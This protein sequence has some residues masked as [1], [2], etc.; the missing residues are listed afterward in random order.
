MDNFII[1]KRLGL[2]LAVVACLS[3]ARS[4]E[5]HG[6]RPSLELA[7]VSRQAL[8][9]LVNGNWRVLKELT[10]SS[11][12]LIVKR[13]FDW[14]GTSALAATGDQKSSGK[15]PGE[16][17]GT[18]KYGYDL[19]FSDVSPS[20]WRDHQV[21][22]QTSEFDST[23]FDSTVRQFQGLVLNSEDGYKHSISSSLKT[24]DAWGISPI[25]PAMYGKV[26]SNSWWYICFR[27]EGASGQWKIWKLELFVH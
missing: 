24:A 23:A 19:N 16:N 7:S 27:R 3:L 8:N 14:S 17:H 22:F 13:E 12:L 5:A 2:L 18:S 25:G 15:M 9:S 6:V 11:G 1:Y 21:W 20:V 26:A 10:S 4:S